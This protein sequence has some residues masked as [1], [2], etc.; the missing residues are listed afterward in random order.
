MLRGGSHDPQNLWDR[1]ERVYSWGS[2]PLESGSI[3]S[4]LPSLPS[5][6]LRRFS[7][8]WGSAHVCVCVCV[9]TAVTSFILAST[10]STIPNWVF[11]GVTK[12]KLYHPVCVATRNKVW[13]M[14]WHLR[15][16]LLGPV[17]CSLSLCCCPWSWKWTVFVMCIVLAE[18]FASEAPKNWN[19][20]TCTDTALE[21]HIHHKLIHILS[22][23][24]V[25]KYVCIKLLQYL[26]PRT[27][28]V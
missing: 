12:W 9:C 21:T 16:T 28:M 22:W 4:D 7:G 8:F 20:C 19:S 13:F 10:I 27:K 6:F 24:E 1:T 5:V 23:I 26:C 25:A 15:W 3:W 14:V 18:G 11:S 2:R 17:I